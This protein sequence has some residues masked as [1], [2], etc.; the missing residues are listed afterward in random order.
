MQQGQQQRQQ[1][2]QATS[3]SSSW[4]L[5]ANS[6]DGWTLQYGSDLRDANPRDSLNQQQ[7]YG[8]AAQNAGVAN[9]ASRPRQMNALPEL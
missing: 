2:Q 7:Q 5:S 9:G 6:T 4:P 3:S 8:G 1:Q